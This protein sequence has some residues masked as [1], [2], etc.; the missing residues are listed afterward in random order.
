LEIKDSN[1]VPEEELKIATTETTQVAQQS[2]QYW[3]LQRAKI[4]GCDIL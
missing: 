4:C 1:V 2:M 3:H